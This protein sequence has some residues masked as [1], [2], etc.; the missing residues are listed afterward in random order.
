ML[1]I[2][3]PKEWAEAI[4]DFLTWGEGRLPISVGQFIMLLLGF[5]FAYLFVPAV[6]RAWRCK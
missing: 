2:E 1:A 6:I 3:K 4:M 5:G